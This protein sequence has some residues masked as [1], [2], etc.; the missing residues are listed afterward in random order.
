MP[1]LSAF[2]VTLN[3]NAH[4]FTRAISPMAS[5]MAATRSSTRVMPLDFG[6]WILD[7]GLGGHPRLC[8]Y[9]SFVISTS[10]FTVLPR[11]RRIET[12]PCASDDCVLHA[13]FWSGYGI[14]TQSGYGAKIQNPKPKIQ[15]RYVR[16]RMI[17]PHSLATIVRFL[18]CARRRKKLGNCPAVADNVPYGKNEFGGREPARF[19][20]WLFGGMEATRRTV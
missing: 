1:V 18:A 11:G 6:F 19:G 5:S 17:V 2:R 13:R 16:D 15:N 8:A 9:R 20:F 12:P 14:T 7:F 3:A 10:P 4:R